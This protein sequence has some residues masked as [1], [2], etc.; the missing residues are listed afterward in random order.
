[1]VEYQLCYDGGRALAYQFRDASGNFYQA[2]DTSKCNTGDIKTMTGGYVNGFR[3]RYKPG[4]SE[5]KEIYAYQAICSA[6]GSCSVTTI[7]PPANMG[8]QSYIMSHVIHTLT[9]PTYA[10]TNDCSEAMTYTY[11]VINLADNSADTTHTSWLTDDSTNFVFNI[12]TTNVAHAGNYRITV[13]TTLNSITQTFDIDVA[14]SNPCATASLTLTFS[15]SSDIVIDSLSNE[16]R[17]IT[18]TDSVST[19]YSQTNACGNYEV[20]TSPSLS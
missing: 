3:F 20:S 16:S 10:F 7:T 1:M 15:D 19:A 9:T 6:G 12:A 4:D 5:R 17:T 18:I 14:I 2:G 11:S 8:T 13:S